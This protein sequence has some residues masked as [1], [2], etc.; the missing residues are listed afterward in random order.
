[1]WA[2]VVGLE[3]RARGLDVD[4]LEA[5]LETLRGYAARRFPDGRLL[6]LDRNDE[7]PVADLR[8]MCGPE[9]G[10]HLLFLPEEYGG[11]GGGTLDVYRVCE[12]LAAIDLGI[13][14]GVCVGSMPGDVIARGGTAQQKAM[15][16]RRIADEGLL[17]AYGATEPQAGSDLGALTTTAVPVVESG[18]LVGYRI[19][20]RKQWISNGGIADVYSILANAPGGPTWFLVDA[21]VPGFEHGRPEDKQGL[22][23]SNTAAL[24]LDGVYVDVD[25]RVGDAEGQGLLVA[26]GV[27]GYSRVMVATLG[28]G[29]GWAALDRAIAYA[30]TR[31][32]GGGPLSEKQGYTHKLL[33]PHVVRLEAARS[34][35]EDS[36]ERIDAGEGT[37]NTEGAIAKYMGTEAGHAAADASIQ[38]LG[39]YGYT[40]EYMVEKITRDVRI[41]RIFEGTSEI[42]EMTIARDRWQQHLKSAGRYYQ[43]EAAG[44]EALHASDRE[45]GADVA[46]LMFSALAEIME[47]ARTDRLTRSQH[48]LFRLGELIAWAE[49]AASLS[50]RAARA[51]R[52]EMHPKAVLRFTPDV[53]AALARILARQAA[54]KVAEDGLG[55]VLGAQAP[56]GPR[57]EGLEAALR[58]AEI[59]TAQRG[60]VADM[61][62]VAA[63]LHRAAP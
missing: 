50:R 45:V 14:T 51:A 27:F 10:I 31:I 39:G 13:A 43:D 35:I 18:S 5:I 8:A 24:F 55:W 40:R 58:L 16:L 53:M 54:R 26:Q 11:I 57:E 41:T 33:V 19:T 29:A 2:V 37:L 20:G 34:F 7:A 36:A 38:A 60:L 48:V 12:Q 22:R 44:M 1:V 49:C 63:A 15:W 59:H 28:L 17:M 6:E 42:M 9:L 47:R 3:Q 21:G 30:A 61:D 32:Q 46:A 62:R 25:R 56:G 23:A 4:T 52:G